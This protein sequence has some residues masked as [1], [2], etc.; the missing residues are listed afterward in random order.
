MGGGSVQGHAAAQDGVR[1]QP[2][3]RLD[4]GELDPFLQRLQ[5]VER[6]RRFQPEV[7]G[8]GRFVTFGY[9]NAGVDPVVQAAVRQAVPQ[10]A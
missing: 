6:C 1:V 8:T 9:L 10:G 4:G 5:I 3:H 7:G 2:Q